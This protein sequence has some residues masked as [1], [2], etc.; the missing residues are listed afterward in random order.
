MNIDMHGRGRA[1]GT[2]NRTIKALLVVYFVGSVGIALP[3]L[4]SLGR[5]GDLVQTT[6]GKILGAAV[7][8]LGVGALMA[9]RDP[10]RNRVLI[11]V[12]VLF[13]SLSALAIAYRLVVEHRP[14][15]P[16]R[17]LLVPAVAAPI[18]FIVFY[19]R[20]SRP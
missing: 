15:D 2:I 13:T 14:D 1:E 16:A 6:S 8:S 4:F 19:P 18:L 7:L 3:L 17:F 11:Q 9:A 20:P 12:L 10:W 5:A